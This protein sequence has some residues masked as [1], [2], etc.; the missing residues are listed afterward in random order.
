MGDA[1]FAALVHDWRYF[2]LDPDDREFADDE[3]YYNMIDT[4]IGSIRAR[5]IWRGVRIGG[6][7]PWGR[8]HA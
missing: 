7:L 2:T 3:F 6:W 8:R 1:L 4:G 5:L